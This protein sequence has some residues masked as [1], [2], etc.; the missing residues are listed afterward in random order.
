MSDAVDY[1]E[2]T[3]YEQLEVGKY[4][5]RKAK[6]DFATEWRVDQCY[7]TGLGQDPDYCTRLGHFWACAKNHEH[8]FGHSIIKGPIS[9]PMES[10]P[11]VS[12]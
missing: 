8:L 2:V 3:S 1:P 9:F 12:E 4:Y 11:N 6:A 10:A 5:W 7:N